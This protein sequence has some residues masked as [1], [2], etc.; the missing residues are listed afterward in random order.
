MESTAENPR[1]RGLLK[2]FLLACISLVLLLQARSS[3]PAF[4]VLNTAQWGSGR[5]PADWQIKMN[6]GK[7]DISVCAETESC[8]HLKS[9]KSS[10]ALQHPVDVNPSEMPYLT[11][12][13]QVAHLPSGG[14]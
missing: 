10:F 5:L 13:W 11:W 4:I 12:Q 1:V 14:D 2:K 8:L 6:H 3:P 9:V 7:P